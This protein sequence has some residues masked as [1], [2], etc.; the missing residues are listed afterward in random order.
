MDMKELTVEQK[1]IAAATALNALSEAMKKHVTPAF[2]N[3][4]RSMK[5]LSNELYKA[6]LSIHKKITHENTHR[7]S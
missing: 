3:A 6:H 1:A 7:P 4:M 5:D 2:H